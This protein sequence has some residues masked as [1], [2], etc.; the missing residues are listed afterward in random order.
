LRNNAWGHYRPGL[1]ASFRRGYFTGVCTAM[2]ALILRLVL[3]PVTIIVIVNMAVCR[4]ACRTKRSVGARK[5]P[6]KL[7][8]DLLIDRAGMGFLLVHA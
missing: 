6:A 4:F 2:L 7:K 1:F 5:T 3:F 8:G